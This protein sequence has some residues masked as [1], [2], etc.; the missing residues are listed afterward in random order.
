STPLLGHGTQLG[1]PDHQSVSI[2]LVTI[3]ICAEWSLA[4]ATGS[5]ASTQRQRWSV[6][7]G[8]AWALAIWNTAYEPLILFLIVIMLLLVLGRNAPHSGAAT[9]KSRVFGSIIF[10]VVIVCALLIERSEE[11]RV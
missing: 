10:L 5:S 6:V 11:R 9:A 7:S 2:L 8:A 4:E 1:R 3:A